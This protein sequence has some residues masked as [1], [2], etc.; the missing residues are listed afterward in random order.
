[1]IAGWMAAASVTLAAIAGEASYREMAAKCMASL[2]EKGT[3]RYGDV[4]A[5]IWVLN[6]DLDTLECFPAYND[7]V[8][9]LQRDYA[10][11]KLKLYSPLVPYGVGHRII[12]VSQRPAGCA[13]L[14]VDQPMIRAA[15]LHDLLYGEGPFTQAVRDYVHYYLHH[16]QDE[17]TGLIEWGV[18]TSYNVFDEDYS[19]YD[20]RLHEVQVILPLW[21]NLHA[22]EPDI[23]RPYLERFWR[24]HTD[25]ET[26]RVD[27]HHNTGGKGLGFAMAAGEIILVCGY[28]HTLEPDQPWADRALQI[29]HAHWDARNKDTDLFPDRAYGDD[30][31]FDRR[32]AD[33]S[34][35]G[36][37]A[38]RV[39]LAG[40]LTGNAEL[41]EM[42]QRT[43]RA[44]ARYGWDE[45]ADLPWAGL[46][47]D[48]RAVNKTRDYAAANYDK[49]DPTG[50]W[51]LWKDY[52]YGFEAPFAT[53]MTY[54]MAA[55]WL[56]DEELTAQAKRLAACYRRHLP[57]NG[58]Q[59]S[60]AANY[61]QLISFFLA[62]ETL[63]GDASYRATAQQIA[64]EAVGHLWTGTM[65]RGFKGRSHYTAIEGAGY[66][67]QALLEIEADPDRLNGLRQSNLFLWNL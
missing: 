27:R 12:R 46:L 36:F 31:R 20:G 17:K 24:L 34:I 51:D 66:L 10:A 50:H 47:P 67:V 26:G 64:Q 37:W 49:F 11:G 28:L 15:L 25:H 19:A 60:F 45:E 13:N 44:W 54:A 55:L 23:V 57:A 59:G 35:T 18:H 63:T 48:G 21:P 53:L 16:F 42:A 5:P 4:H 29:A 43:L 1:M 58:D 61:G 33:T 14:L 8:E 41:T 40:R 56:E 9:A 3:D 52:V 22:V 6:L 65:F 7:R 30:Q 32:H 2:V 62:M 38:S 39:L